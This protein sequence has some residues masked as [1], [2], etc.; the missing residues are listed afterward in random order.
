MNQTRF[1]NLLAALLDDRITEA[2]HNELAILVTENEELRGEYHRQIQFDESLSLA[3]D[4]RRDATRFLELVELRIDAEDQ[5]QDFVDRVLDQTENHHPRNYLTGLVPWTAV[6]LACC[7]A[8][9][10]LIG[11]QSAQ[12]NDSLQNISV[13]THQLPEP[14]DNGVA[15]FKQAIEVA[16]AAEKSYKVG[17]SVAPGQLIHLESGLVQIQFFHGA[18]VTLQGPARLVVRDLDTALLHEGQV[19]VKVPPPARGFTLHT[20]DTELVDLGTEFGVSVVPGEHTEVRVFDGLVELYDPQTNRS[21]DS[22]RELTTGE[23]LV[24]DSSGNYKSAP[25]DGQWAQPEKHLYNK[26]QQQ[27]NHR[28]QRWQ[29]WSQQIAQDPRVL[30]YYPFQPSTDSELRFPNQAPTG[31]MI[32]GTII[33]C[34]WST[35]RFPQKPSLEFKR[36]SDRIRFDLPGEYDSITL[37]AWVRLD[38]LDRQFNSLMLTDGW[39]SGEIHWQF[40]RDGGL[41]L[42]LNGGS[43]GSNEYTQPLVDLRQLGQWIHVASVYDAKQQIIRHLFNGK[44]IYEVPSIANGP[45]RIGPAELGNW[46]CTIDP[47]SPIRNFNGRMDEFLIFNTALNQSE[48][49]QIYQAGNPYQ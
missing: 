21:S 12:Q 25:N 40:R 39:E 45:L 33:G 8:L 42:A 18:L 3:I 16:W 44:T 24:V 19:W 46:H 9:I 17:D 14:A 31:P 22:R 47:A 13:A 4:H 23:G 5:E 10:C 43:G 32:E 7:F 38:G 26:Q 1:H 34:A 6:A 11:W 30:L 37:A 29:A 41:G 20:T 2:E 15:V 27:L 36:P 49:H 35:G 48:I 28:Y